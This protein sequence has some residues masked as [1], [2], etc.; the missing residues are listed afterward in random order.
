MPKLLWVKGPHT[1]DPERAVQIQWS[2]GNT[3]NFSCEYCPSILHN[4]TKPWLP[5][6]QY[7]KVVDKISNHYRS[8]N[9]FMHWELLGGEVT[10][11]PDF[12]KIIERIAMYNSSVTV[13]TNGSRTIDWWKEAREYLTGVVI[14]YHPLTM[15]VQHLYDVVDVLKDNLILDINIA[16]IGGQVEQLSDVVD[17]LR[18]MFLGS[19]MQSVYDVNI[20]IKTMYKK[21]L[22]EDNNHHKQETYYN[23]TPQEI[24]IMQRPGLL[25]NPNQHNEYDDPNDVQDHPRFWSTEFMYEDAPPKYV[26]SHQII[27][28]GLNRFKGMKCELGFD[29]LNIDMNGEV[30]SS[31]CGAKNFGNITQLDNWDIPKTETRCPFEFCNNLNDISITKTL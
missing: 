22:G 27:N 30:I 25:P 10:T 20:T 26:Q 8:K 7:L 4:G 23:Y 24:K 28:E 16:G 1:T 6:D 3:C 29:S 17:N 9:R 2:M 31:W 13:Y 5:T 11:I 21:Y 18:N 12:E 15:D 19:E 14:T